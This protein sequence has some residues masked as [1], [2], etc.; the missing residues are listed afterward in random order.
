MRPFIEELQAVAPLFVSCYPNAG[1]P[2]AFGGFDETP[3]RM[4][5]DLHDFAKSGFVNMVGGCCGSTPAH[6]TAIAQ[7]VRGLKPRVFLFYS[8]LCANR[9][10]YLSSRCAGPVQR[11]RQGAWP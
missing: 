10:H 6:I 4:A 2:N 11:R 9:K 7:A 3:E 5:A 8:P 1:L